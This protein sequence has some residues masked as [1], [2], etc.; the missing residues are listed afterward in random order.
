MGHTHTHTHHTHTQHTQTHTFTCM[1]THIHMHA[2]THTHTTTHVDANIITYKCKF[3]QTDAQMYIHISKS[4][5]K[6]EWE[7]GRA[8]FSEAK[9]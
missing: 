4:I 3:K 8:P 6:G 9:C 2:H 7:F 5:G 1:H